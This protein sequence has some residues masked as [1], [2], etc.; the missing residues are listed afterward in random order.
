[1]FFVKEDY[2]KYLRSLSMLA[3]RNVRSCFV[4][5]LIGQGEDEHFYATFHKKQQERETERERERKRE[6]EREREREER[7]RERSVLGR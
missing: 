1:L 2:S 5:F 4:C 6:R 7:L 3:S